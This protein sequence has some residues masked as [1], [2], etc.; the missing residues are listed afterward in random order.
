MSTKFE[1]IVG[2]RL[3]VDLAERLEREARENLESLSCRLRKVVA[4]HFRT[5]PEQGRAA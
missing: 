1:G 5:Q 2:T 4:E 3:P